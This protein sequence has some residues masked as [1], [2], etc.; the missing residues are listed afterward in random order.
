MKKYKKRYDQTETKLKW[1]ILEKKM[2]YVGKFTW[3]IH[4][5]F[6]NPKERDF[7]FKQLNSEEYS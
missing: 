6:D 4:S 3:V 1:Q 5:T 2:I 7:W